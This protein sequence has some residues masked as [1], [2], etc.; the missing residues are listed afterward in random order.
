VHYLITGHTGFK[1]AWLAL[2]L[3][4]RGHDVSGF[5]LDPLPGSLFEVAEVSGDLRH[6]VRGDVRDARVV[7]RALSETRPDVVVHMAAQPLVRTSLAQPRETV[8]TNVLGTLNL[9]EAVRATDE[10]RALLVI[11]TDKVYADERP[12]RPHAEGDPLGGRD[13]YSVSKAMA[14][15]LTL[16]WRTSFLGSR[17]AT[18]RAGNVI[19]GGDVSR[20]RLLPDLLRAIAEGQRPLIRYPG[21]IRP[22]QH[23]LD[24]LSGYLALIEGMVA[25]AIDSQLAAWNFGPVGD[26]R[27]TVGQVADRVCALWGE[28]AGWVLDEA[29]NPP[30][31]HELTLDASQAV[32]E[33]LWRPR[34]DAQAALAL[35]VEWAKAVMSG[36][37][38]RATTLHQIR[39]YDDAAATGPAY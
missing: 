13:P 23:V 37:S 8:E 22:W 16:A 38:A 11:T 2:L 5:A 17:A 24:A 36:Q 28:N 12:P 30:E 10:V 19:G 21:A 27:L 39:A 32:R 4:D 29:P 18:A 25:G 31:T 1:G 20:D 15:L 6:D 33:L 35:T 34:L 14:D 26:A 9:L 7:T 3:R